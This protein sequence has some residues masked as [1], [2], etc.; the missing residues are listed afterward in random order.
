MGAS[1][2][3]LTK[4]FYEQLRS[5]DDDLPDLEAGQMRALDEEDLKH[6]FRDV[7]FDETKTQESRTTVASTMAERGPKLR[8]IMSQFNG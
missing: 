1:P 2:R 7:Q 6:E 8:T 5:R 4:S 3:N